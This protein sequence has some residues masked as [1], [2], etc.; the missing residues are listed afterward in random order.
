MAV[1]VS[2]EGERVLAG[3]L[4]QTLNLFD[5]TGKTVWSRG[6]GSAV[7]GAALTP[8]GTTLAFGAS[9][10]D[11][12]LYTLPAGPTPTPTVS[13]T[14]I[15]TTAAMTG[16]FALSS[17]PDGAAVLI[18]NLYVGRTPVTVPDLAPGN[19]TV[20]LELEGYEPWSG[21][22]SV[23]AGATVAVNA[24]LSL[25]PAQTQTRAAG[26]PLIALAGAGIAAAFLL[27]RRK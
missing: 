11:V 16:S 2:T 7:R 22:F 27:A 10:G 18:D 25:K 3:S 26:S 24:T 15:P 1:S 21:A 23:E 19:H 20:L 17:T 13:V 14:T 8:D 4:D 5:R 9:N 12:S 6:I